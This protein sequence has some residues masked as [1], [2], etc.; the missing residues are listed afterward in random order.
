[1]FLALEIAGR[2]SSLSFSYIGDDVHFFSTD[3]KKDFEESSR[4]A[5]SPAHA[6]LF[7]QV[8][9]LEAYSIP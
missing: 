7:E 6:A 4:A 3:W 1:V 9:N 5:T 8:N 2:G